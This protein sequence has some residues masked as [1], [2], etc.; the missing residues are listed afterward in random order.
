LPVHQI[1]QGNC[2]GPDADPTSPDFNPLL[3]VIKWYRYDV[4]TD[5][6]PYTASRDHDNFKAWREM[7]QSNA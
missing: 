1:Y 3:E 4:G 2:F 5:N 6:L 7:L